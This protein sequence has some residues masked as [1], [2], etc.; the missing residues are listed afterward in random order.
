M[1]N[2]ADDFSSG[3][4]F[5]V[6]RNLLSCVGS[7]KLN[8]ILAVQVSYNKI[9]DN[10]ATYKALA[11]H[12]SKLILRNGTCCRKA[13]PETFGDTASCAIIIIEC[14]PLHCLVGAFLCH[15]HR[16]NGLQQDI[17]FKIRLLGDVHTCIVHLQRFIVASRFSAN[18]ATF[19]VKGEAFYM[20]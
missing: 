2:T 5:G 19:F 15:Y 17:V 11:V 3:N 6:G 9:F 12:S 20:E 18:G 16:E 8:R 1:L 7:W 4:L 14:I 10:G 13:R